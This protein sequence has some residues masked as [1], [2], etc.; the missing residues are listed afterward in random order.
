MACG[1]AGVVL[2]LLMLVA[3]SGGTAFLGFVLVAAGGVIGVKGW[4]AKQVYDAAYARAIPRPSDQD[5]DQIIGMDTLSIVNR[6]LPQ[7]G[8]TADDLVE[9][10]GVTRASGARF[11]D[12]LSK[13]GPKDDRPGANQLVVSGPALPCHLA[14]GLDSKLRYSKYAFM[15]ICPTNYHLAVYRCELD[16]YTG[17]LGF[18]RTAEY[19]YADVVAIQTQTL[20]LDYRRGIPI[21]L[22]P[23]QSDASRRLDSQ[24]TMEIVVASG[25]RVSITLSICSAAD[26][27]VDSGGN[28]ESLEFQHVLQRVRQM[29]REK[30]GGTDSADDRR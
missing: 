26:V 11:D 3:G 29:L 19:H 14:I 10:R 21:H 15:V 7:L 23:S 22:R 8:L 2:G 17:A 1:G 30:K 20:P 24:L 27:T 9:P 16:L 4:S 12:L 5:I 18:E 25:D 13:T 28:S 6:S